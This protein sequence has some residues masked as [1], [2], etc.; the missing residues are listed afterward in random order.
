MATNKVNTSRRAPK[1]VV[2][3]RKMI[4]RLR[5]GRMR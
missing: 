2:K 1:H 5:S 3:R 4:K